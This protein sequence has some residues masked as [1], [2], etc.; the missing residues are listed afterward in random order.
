MWNRGTGTES[1]GQGGT[2]LKVWYGSGGFKLD[3]TGLEDGRRYLWKIIKI[4]VRIKVGTA[5]LRSSMG[6]AC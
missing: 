1:R 4:I 6:E 3:G 2:M 5:R